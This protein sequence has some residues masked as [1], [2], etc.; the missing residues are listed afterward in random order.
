MLDFLTPLALLFFY[1]LLD[2]S[3]LLDFSCNCGTL[4]CGI[5]ES[6]CA[7]AFFV[8]CHDSFELLIFG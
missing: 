4:E 8:S 5:S 7:S 2:I 3:L 1:V 6:I